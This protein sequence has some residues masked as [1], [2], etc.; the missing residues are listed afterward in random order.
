MES[1]A[2]DRL[3]CR[4]DEASRLEPGWKAP[5]LSRARS[6]I[7]RRVGSKG[8]CPPCAV[9]VAVSGRAAFTALSSLAAPVGKFDAAIP[10]LHGTLVQQGR[11]PNFDFYS[12]YPPLSL[13]MNA[14][15]FSLLGRSAVA[16][17]LVADVF[18]IGV[19]L[20]TAWFFSSRYRTSGPLVPVAVLLVAASIGALVTMPSWLGLSLALAALLTYLCS[21]G[22]EQHRLWV[23]AGAGVLTG[24]AILTRINFGGYAAAV[25]VLDLLLQ[26]VRGLHD[27]PR[28]DGISLLPHSPR[29]RLPPPSALPEYPSRSTGRTSASRSRNSSSRLSD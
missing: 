15:A 23:V 9:W 1:G 8:P 13:Y 2:P 28:A 26:R 5:W 21:Q 12:F 18:F 22:L 6:T 14:A 24:L 4:S 19:L 7:R 3:P 20:L 25:I 17:R 10:L 27:G 11:T 16:E 29:S